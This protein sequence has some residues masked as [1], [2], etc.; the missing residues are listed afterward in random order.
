MSASLR[1]ASRE[2]LARLSERVHEDAPDDPAARGSELFAVVDLLDNQPG[3]RR[4]LTDPG[5]VDDDRA[6]L[7]GS[8]FSGQVSEATADVVV[9]AARQRWARA[10]DMGDALEYLS[11]VLQL[12]DAERRDQIDRVEDELFSFAEAIGG[13]AALGSALGDTSAPIDSRVGLVENLLPDVDP[14]TRTL[15]RRAV[16]APRGGTVADLLEEFSRIAADVRQRLV[17]TVTSAVQL[18]DAERDRL[19]RALAAQYGRDVHLNVIV[20]PDV[21]G[22]VSVTI[23]DDII[24]GTIRSRLS[25]VARRLAG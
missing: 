6:G 20:N 25:D 24:D 21:I 14:V 13:N 5:R 16:A 9:L 8:V 17:A 10:R 12:I 23:G 15:A 18:A 3:L 7:A 11:A 2:S 19:R 4:A 1:G 22:G